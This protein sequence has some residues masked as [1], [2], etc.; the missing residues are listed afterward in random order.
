MKKI[1][2]LLVAILVIPVALLSQ[3][4][5]EEIELYQSLF[6]MEKKALVAEFVKVEGDAKDAF[7]T[8]YDQ[9]EVERKALGQNRI[10]LLQDYADSY[11]Q[12]DDTK[13]DEIMGNALKQ[14]ANLDK[15]LNKYYKKI[16]AECGSQ[17]AAQ[18]WQ[19]E[20]YIVSATRVEI[21]ENIPLI[22]E[23]D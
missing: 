17:A 6:G 3:S 20:S 7:W 22:G 12:L 2:Y 15:V 11:F 21:F 18:F 5:K 13:I 8:L 10:A 4:N 16:K 19:I 14:K 9:Y 23:L 1:L